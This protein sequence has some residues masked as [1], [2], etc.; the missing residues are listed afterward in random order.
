MKG[1]DTN[2]IS[3]KAY[4]LTNEGLGGLIIESS[5]PDLSRYSGSEESLKEKAVNA[6]MLNENT[7]HVIVVLHTNE[8][9]DGT[10][11]NIAMKNY[12]EDLAGGEDWASEPDTEEL[13]WVHN[14]K[15]LTTK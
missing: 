8:Y 6:L 2:I 14:Y 7:P 1:L 5:F 10:E 4:A 13:V 11:Y 9:C 15:P 3:I 12:Y